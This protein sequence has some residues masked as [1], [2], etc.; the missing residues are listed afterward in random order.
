MPPLNPTQMDFEAIPFANHRS[1]TAS[2]PHV[3]VETNQLVCLCLRWRW[4]IQAGADKR[5]SLF[6]HDLKPIHQVPHQRSG[7]VADADK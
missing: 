4:S 6:V 7:G 2:R 3:L 5:R 1:P